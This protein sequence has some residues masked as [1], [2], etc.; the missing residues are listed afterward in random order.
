M[1]IAILSRVMFLII[2]HFYFS[3]KGIM[4]LISLVFSRKYNKAGLFL[5]L[6]GTLWQDLGPGG[7]LS[8]SKK[9]HNFPKLSS[10]YRSAFDFTFAISNQTLFCYH[11]KL[12]IQTILYYRRLLR[13]IMKDFQ[14]DAM[15]V[16]YHHPYSNNSIFRRDCRYRK[17]SSDGINFFSKLF[18]IE[19]Q[20]SVLIGDR[21]TDVMSGVDASINS[22]LLIR[23]N[24]AMEI[25]KVNESFNFC[26]TYRFKLIESV[27]DAI[28][29][30]SKSEL[31]I[32]ILSAGMGLRLRPITLTTPKPLIL[33]SENV[34]IISRLVGQVYDVFPYSRI[35]IN[36]SYLSQS[37]IDHEPLTPY[38][39]RIHFAWEN[40]LLGGEETLRQAF[41]DTQ[42]NYVVI[43]GDQFVGLKDLKQLKKFM[44]FSPQNSM[45]A[46]HYRAVEDARSLVEID[47][48]TIIS[49]HEGPVE[50]F[51]RK[52]PILVNSGI[53]YF[54]KE[55]LENYFRLE[56]LEKS[57]L[58]EGLIP[59]LVNNNK[60]KLFNWSS[61]RIAIDSIEKLEIARRRLKD[62]I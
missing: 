38:L 32:L 40:Q 15:A 51:K 45:M 21:I 37:F 31:T 48:T 60:L 41:K 11:S 46:C 18:K 43:H 14:I 17:P 16:C 23:N 59:Y 29:Q 20:R 56:H 61:D 36:L 5:D 28:P 33:L 55:D 26:S 7:I 50:N 9:S 57:E 22:N 54:G 27:S 2:P 1:F 47:G 4:R 24:K 10:V 8:Y 58:T 62:S 39:K 12:D 35:L 44:E 6:D 49:F 25:N 13:N 34:S 30:S 42:N 53:Y 52:S 19:K 3:K